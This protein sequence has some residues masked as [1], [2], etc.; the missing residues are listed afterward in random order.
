MP[1]IDINIKKVVWEDKSQGN[2]ITCYMSSSDPMLE[3][4]KIEEESALHIAVKN[5]NI[6]I[7]ELLLTNE[8]IDFNVK[9]NNEKTPIEITDDD[10]IRKLIAS[11]NH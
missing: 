10:K 8:N 7:L 5:K 4:P 3:Y 6:E 1:S 2:C 9:D 11:A